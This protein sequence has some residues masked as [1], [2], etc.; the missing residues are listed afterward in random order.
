[1]KDVKLKDG[2]V[3]QIDEDVLDDMELIDDLQDLIA[4]D[5]TARTKV[6]N[7]VFGDSKKD[8][9]NHFRTESGRVPVSRVDEAFS[10]VIAQL[11]AKN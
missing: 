5:R 4:G 3:L 8:L 9:Y 6:F 1:M 11:N 7:K 2:F 10:E